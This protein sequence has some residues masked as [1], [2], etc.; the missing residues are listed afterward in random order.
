MSRRG[1]HPPGLYPRGRRL[2]VGARRGGVAQTATLPTPDEALA[3]RARAVAAAEGR[4]EWNHGEAQ[5]ELLDHLGH[6]SSKG[7][8]GGREPRTRAGG[9]DRPR[10]RRQTRRWRGCRA[11]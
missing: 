9:E 8:D 11:E 7:A 1:N 5:L 4:G 2:L 10:R 3:W 6:A